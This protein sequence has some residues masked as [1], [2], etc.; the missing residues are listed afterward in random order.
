MKSFA[1][2]LLFVLPSLSALA[3]AAAA[4]GADEGERRNLGGVENGR[5]L[6]K[7]F[8]DYDAPVTFV[9]AISPDAD[10]L[11]ESFELFRDL[12]GGDNNMDLVKKK[13]LKEG[14]RQINWDAAAVPFDM[15]GDFF[16][17]TVPRGCTVR[18][19]SDEFRVS[20]PADGGDDLFDSINHKAAKDFQAFTLERLFTS[21]EENV[22]TIDFSVPGFVDRPAVVDGFGA[23]FVDVKEAHKTKM[24]FF[25]KS[26]C[27]IAEEYVK[28][29]AKGLS[30]L[31]AFSSK[32]PIFKVEVVLGEVAIDDSS[33][34]KGDD[35]VVMD[36]FIYSEPQAVTSDKKSSKS[37]KTK[38][39]RK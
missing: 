30:F 12:L 33:D 16:A 14:H 13:G 1:K 10:G 11:K 17:A 31:G 28:P 29:L 8:C 20:N 4:D 9:S 5:A 21:V 18:S 7:K 32:Y 38:N 25:A 39:S 24:T 27:I 35:V 34:W 23:V 6:K 37:G 36:D 19:D 26:G 22:F 2:I 3:A 15:P